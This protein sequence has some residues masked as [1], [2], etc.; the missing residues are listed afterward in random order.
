M[1]LILLPAFVNG[2][3]RKT[4]LDLSILHLS[5]PFIPFSFIN[6]NPEIFILVFS[7]NQ[8]CLIM[9]H[10][11]KFSDGNQL[12]YKSFYPVLL[13]QGTSG[14]HRNHIMSKH[15][16]KCAHLKTNVLQDPSS[17]LF[18]HATSI[19]LVIRCWFL[20]KKYI[21]KTHSWIFTQNSKRFSLYAFTAEQGW[22][23][24]KIGKGC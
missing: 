18:S 20:P 23:L 24:A 11:Y 4:Y 5:I 2:H 8:M 21:K 6:L 19:S 14:C 15:V 1:I 10:Y 17:V 16:R 3:W 9:Q 12:C 7:K 13:L 22:I